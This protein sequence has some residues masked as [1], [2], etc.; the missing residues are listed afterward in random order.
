M[1]ASSNTHSCVYRSGYDVSVPLAPEKHYRDL[2]AIAPLDRAFFLTFKVCTH[3]VCRGHGLPLAFLFL[4]LDVPL[5][6]RPD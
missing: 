4:V 6:N 1:D 5:H 2:A 3:M